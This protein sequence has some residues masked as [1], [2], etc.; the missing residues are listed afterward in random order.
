MK[1]TPA[2]A[3]RQDGRQRGASGRTVERRFDLELREARRIVRE[4]RNSSDDF[5]FTLTPMR[6]PG[7]HIQLKACTVTV[8]RGEYPRAIYE[9]EQAKNWVVLFAHDLAIHRFSEGDSMEGSTRRDRPDFYCR[10]AK[11]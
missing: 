8:L 6:Q 10:Q 2:N 7:G 1:L 5:R 3:T 9:R 4:H 11:P